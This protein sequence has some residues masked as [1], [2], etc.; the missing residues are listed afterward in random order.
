[1]HPGLIL[2]GALQIVAAGSEYE[3]ARPPGEGVPR[4]AATEDK[5][6][7]HRQPRMDSPSFDVP[8]RRGWLVV[9]DKHLVRTLEGVDLTIGVRV[10]DLS[11]GGQSV[12][13]KP[14]D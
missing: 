11:C 14:G 5:L 12:D 9:H 7:V 4:F 2:F 3:S 10:P 8:F 6:V 1:M 13:L